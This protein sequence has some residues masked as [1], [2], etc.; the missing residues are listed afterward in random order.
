MSARLSIM[1]KAQEVIV[2]SSAASLVKRVVGGIFTRILVLG[3]WRAVFTGILLLSVLACSTTAP[4]QEPPTPTALPLGGPD[5][6]VILVTSD[7]AG[8]TN[9][10][11]FGLID[12]D[13]MPVRTDQAQVQSV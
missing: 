13:G 7:L 4:G 9:R 2:A 12:R 8:G 1:Q 3:N 6:S 5:Y 11:S 10:V